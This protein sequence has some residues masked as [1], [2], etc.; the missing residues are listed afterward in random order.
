MKLQISTLQINKEVLS[1]KQ[2]Q[3]L[4]F[5]ITEVHWVIGDPKIV[6]SHIFFSIRVGVTKFLVTM[7]HI[8]IHR[9]SWK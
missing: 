8:K 3:I 1:N 9:L 6:R 7:H 2:F 5:S 4:L